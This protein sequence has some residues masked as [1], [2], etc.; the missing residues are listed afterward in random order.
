MENLI[1]D[2]KAL[3]VQNKK[4]AIIENGTWAP[5]A[6]KLLKAEL[7]SMKNMEQVGETLTVKSATFN[8]EALDAL[9]C[10]IAESLK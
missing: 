7:D 1:Q 4:Y 2:M 9:A 3:T 8:L 10:A 5:A 6:G